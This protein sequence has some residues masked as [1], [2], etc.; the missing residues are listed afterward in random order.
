MQT[1]VVRAYGLKCVVW[2]VDVDVDVD[3]DVETSGCSARG[4]KAIKR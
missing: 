3:G 1:S 4:Y 2:H